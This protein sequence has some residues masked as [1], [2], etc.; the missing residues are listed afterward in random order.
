MSL[1]SAAAPVLAFVA[2][3]D[4][5]HHSLNPIVTGGGAFLVLLFLLFLMTRF[6]KDR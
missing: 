5:N 4:D 2:D 1:H 3:G 6:N